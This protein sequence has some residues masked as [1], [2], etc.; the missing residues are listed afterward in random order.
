MAIPALAR[1]MT[2]HQRPAF[3]AVWG[4][5]LA[6]CVAGVYT[7]Q[8]AYSTV[9]LVDPGVRAA[10]SVWVFLPYVAAGLI[11]WWQRPANTF[12]PLMIVAGFTTFL[13]MLGWSSVDVLYTTGVALD[14]LPPVLFLHVFL[15]FPSGHLQSAFERR[16]VGAAY[17]TALVPTIARMTL[18]GHGSNNVLEVTSHPALS[19]AI[20]RV[21]LALG[22][23]FAL[24]GLGVL[25]ARRRREGPPLRRSLT[26]LIDSF[27]LGL[28][29]IAALAW[30]GA[31]DGPDLANVRRLT[32]FVIGAAPIAFLV[33]L[34]QARLARSS[35]GD[36]F[37]E[38]QQDPG[39]EALEGALARALRDPSLVLAYWLPEFASYADLTGRIVDL[40]VGREDRAV[41][42]IERDGVQTAAI[43]H[44]ASL[45]H[46][47]VLLQAVTAAAGIA[48]E[49]A[50]LHATLRAQL[51]ELQ[52][53]RARILDAGR[54]ERKR[55]ERNLHDGAQ[56]RL[57]ALSLELGLRENARST[58][59]GAAAWL[60]SARSEIAASLDELREVA[61]GLHPA[62][63]TGHG[64]AIALEQ[65]V[66]HAPVPMRLE[67]DVGGRL[68]EALEVAAYYLVSESLTNVARHANA[69]SGSIDVSR[70]DA[71]MVVEI[72]DNGVGG[73]DTER[74]SGLRGLADRVETLGGRLRIWSP[75][76]GGTRVRAEIPC[77]P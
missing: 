32:F 66:A 45:R 56:Q 1:G 67:V 30:T 62:V 22:G 39:P 60:A 5:A 20:L 9:G 35:V 64:L 38:L 52:G 49:N 16:L 43:V 41:T 17:A 31:F 58:D 19:D 77:A 37:V 47:P 46:E 33:G 63:V 69:S 7:F 61:R 21:Q 3:A 4:L 70:R 28:V 27:A 71:S 40:P 55:L 44:D 11:A 51:D 76:G 36:L 25:I 24:V 73:A 48:L 8:L 57:I 18:G 50:Q 42:L 6:G 26:L 12:G 23:A 14:L 13:V 65:L 10:L 75:A 68:P 2:R 34:L 54:A 15:A 53:S 59:P 29:M 72:V 74:G